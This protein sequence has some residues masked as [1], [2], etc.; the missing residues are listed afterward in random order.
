MCLKGTFTALITP[1]VNDQVDEKALVNN[2]HHQLAGGITGIVFLG[3]TGESATLTDEEQKKIIE[4]G[5]RETKGKATVIVGTGSNSTRIAIEKTKRAK[6]LGAE[7]ALIVTPYYN[8][9][10]QEGIFRHFEAISSQVD[11]PIL[12]YNIQGRT[13]V[14]IETSTLLR[15]AGLP[16]VIGVKEASGNI[17][18]AGDVLL[19][20][21]KKYPSFTV[22]SGD[23]GLTL[24][25]MS[26]GAHG[27]ISV[28]SNLVP[29]QVVSLVNAALNGDFHTAR[30]VHEELSPLFKLAFIEVNPTPIKYAMN[31]CGMT[32]GH[33]RLPLCEMKRENQ[34]ILA[35]KLHEMGLK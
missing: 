15:I 26:L 16:N 20:V 8:K 21:R 10:T 5:V 12:V 4:V 11:L 30:K 22:L 23:D 25:M 34:E 13:G 28:V 9:P 2:I 33:C 7:M 18:Q 27:V 1:F 35:A 29:N 14:N 31:L 19:T 6:D 32:A 24:P 17:G 3:T